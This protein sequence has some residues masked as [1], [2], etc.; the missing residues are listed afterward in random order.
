MDSNR[1][2]KL[3]QGVR[4]ALVKEVGD[5]LDRV[6]RSESPARLSEPTVVARVEALAGRL[7]HEVLVERVAYTWFNRLCALRFM[8]ER[9]YTPVGIVT[10]RAG[11]TLPAVLAD[12]RRGLFTEGLRLSEGQRHQVSELLDG[13]RAARDPLG[14]AYL[15]LL[16]AACDEYA[17]PMGYLF[18]GDVGLRH[19]MRLL[20][21]AGLLNEGS[22]LERITQGMDAET[23]QSVEVLGWL[24]QFYIAEQ[25]DEFYGSKRKAAAED[26]PAATQLF[27]PRWIV[28]YLVENSLGRL[29][30]LNNPG[31][32]LAERMEYCIAPDPEDTEGFLKVDGPEELTLCDPACGSGHIL[33]YAFELLYAIYEEEGYLPE[34]IPQLILE[35][36]LF[37]MEIDRRAAEI[38]CFALEMCAREK[39]PRFFEKGVDAHIAVLEPVRFDEG[40]L[41][42]AGLIVGNTRLLEAFAHLDEIGS[43]YVPDSG[44]KELVDIA[45]DNLTQAEGMF[46]GTTID[47]LARMRA[48]LDALTGPYTCVVANPPYLGSG[49]FNPFMAKWARENYPD[50]KNDLCTCFIRRGFTLTCA[51][52]YSAMVT[53]HSWMFLGGYEKMRTW[54][55]QNKG[56][57]TMAHLGAHAFDQI[58]GEVVQVSAA[59]FW[60]AHYE[61]QGA[62]VR[63]VDVVGGDEK[64]AALSKAIKNPDCPWRYRADQGEFD[65]IPGS[66]I[67]YWASYD[68]LRAFSLG[69]PL[70]AI[71]APRQGLATADNNRFMRMWWE[72]MLSTMD[73]NIKS[74]D[75]AS[76]SC[77]KWFPCDKGGQFRKWYGNLLYLINWQNDGKELNGFQ[78]SVIR[79]PDIYFKPYIAWSDVSSGTPS[80]R[81]RGI[82]M[83]IEHCANAIPVTG[84]KQLSLLGLLNS[85]VIREALSILSPTL[86]YG[87]GQACS[88][89]V[90]DAVFQQE[91]SIGLTEECINLSR[92]DWD[93]F[94]TSWDFSTHPLTQPG[95]PLI[96]NQFSR[97]QQE[98]DERFSQ[99]K[100]NEEEL[101]R[102]FACIYGMEGEV[103]IE[104]PDDKVSVRRADLVRDV[105][106]L[107]SYGV[108]CIFGRYST[109]APG[110]VLADAQQTVDDF[111]AKVPEASFMPAETNVLP[112]TN[113]EDFSF[114]DDAAR[115]FRAWLADTYGPDTLDDNI[116]FIENALGM[117]L[118]TYFAKDLYKDHCATYQVT[119][120]GKRPIYWLFASPKGSFQALVYMHRMTRDTVSVVLTEYV[121]PFRTGLATRAA[122]LVATGNARDASKANRYRQMVAEVEQWER[123]VLYP[124]SQQ[125]VEID[126]DDGVKVNYKKFGRALAKVQ[127]LS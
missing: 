102:I 23:C 74:R 12:A 24:Y 41:D 11:E 87:V 75:D 66:P 125:H 29:W 18:G 111:T 79:N 71:A 53:M 2:Q 28:R 106:S 46:A 8:D 65:V 69:S 40:E 19:A 33:V 42:E 80:F 109:S 92:I 38:A 121:R 84:D 34:E 89:P 117:D 112:I 70:E 39:D 120:S 13:G 76:S 94:E 27:T 52:G 35:H 114:A 50:E 119:G 10:A 113:V 88:I 100:A 93:S 127:G 54:L 95:E 83:I 101:N 37:G 99:L 91:R 22:V 126:L 55:I 105:K 44:D 4:T 64:A 67:A 123:D 90:L 96:K 85:T 62:Y 97:W 56:I 81:Y 122:E 107:I 17:V 59:A 51:R 103:P 86:H 58:A 15:I 31:S 108:G 98:C 77:A 26:I 21:P 25:H 20:A 7:G 68:L 110:L 6:L 36:N 30:M 115:V 78:N 61:G 1:I 49:K 47:K 3:A 16:L 104:V 82:G 116:S 73:F 9:G 63:L 14:E 48:A 57:L 72:P 118:R 5:S 60:N 32:A 45:I 124:L 43:L